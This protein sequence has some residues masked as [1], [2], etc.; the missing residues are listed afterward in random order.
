MFKEGNSRGEKLT[1]HQA[2]KEL[3]RRLLQIDEEYPECS[4][5]LEDIKKVI[6]MKCTINKEELSHVIF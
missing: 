5:H 2:A 3:L 1:L 4:E 6:E